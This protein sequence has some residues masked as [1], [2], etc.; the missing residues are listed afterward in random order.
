MGQLHDRTGSYVAE[1]IALAAGLLLA[2]L[3]SIE[4]RR[5]LS[6]I[7]RDLA[8]LHN[9]GRGRLG[10]NRAA[11]PI[12]SELLPDHPQ[13]QNAHSHSHNREEDDLDEVSGVLIFQH[14]SDNRTT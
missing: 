5:G 9:C 10:G 1:M 12:A 2:G 4:P 6:D 3:L 8:D 11:H 7:L 13:P 14:V